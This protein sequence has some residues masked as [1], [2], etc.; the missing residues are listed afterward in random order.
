MGCSSCPMG[1]FEDKEKV[2][3][4]VLLVPWDDLLVPWD[5]LF[6]PWDIS[7]IKKMSH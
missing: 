5:A 7:R 1:Y 6:V 2:P 4:D 3:W